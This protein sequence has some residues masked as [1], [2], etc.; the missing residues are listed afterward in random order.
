V[1]EKIISGDKPFL[2]QGWQAMFAYRGDDGEVVLRTSPLKSWT[3]I[4]GSQERWQSYGV[5]EE[6]PRRESIIPTSVVTC[7]TGSTRRGTKR[8]LKPI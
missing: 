4:K 7:A 6:D 1:A 3:L 8:L 5:T 2:P